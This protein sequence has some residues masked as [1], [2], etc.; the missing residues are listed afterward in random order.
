MSFKGDTWPGVKQTWQATS[1]RVAYKQFEIPGVV[2]YMKNF[3]GKLKV[4]GGGGDLDPH[5]VEHGTL[6]TN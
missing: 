4:G 2:D 5:G 6:N 1:K 3:P